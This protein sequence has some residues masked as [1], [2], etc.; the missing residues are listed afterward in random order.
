VKEAGILKW[1]RVRGLSS[2]LGRQGI[3]VAVMGHHVIGIRIIGPFGLGLGIQG[4]E[5]TMVDVD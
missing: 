5:V 2:Y 4:I 1:V 3:L